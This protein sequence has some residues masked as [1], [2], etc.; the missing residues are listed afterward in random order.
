MTWDKVDGIIKIY[1]VIRYLE[2]SDSYDIT[3]EYMMQFLI[4]LK[5]LKAKKVMIN[6]VLIIILQESELIHIIL[7]L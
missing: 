3:I 2:L 7:Y 1:E 4:G 6:L 5:I